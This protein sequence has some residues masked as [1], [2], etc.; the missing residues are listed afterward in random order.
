[1]CT[2][3]KKDWVKRESNTLKKQCKQLKKAAIQDG[4]TGRHTS[5]QSTTVRINTTN[6]KM[7]NTQNCTEVQQPRIYRSYIHPHRKDGQRQ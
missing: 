7:K 6:L 1:M 2:M 3:V 5:P 4:G